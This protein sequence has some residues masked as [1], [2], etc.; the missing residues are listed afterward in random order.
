ME[1]LAN[2][3][4]TA[5]GVLAA[6]GCVV[7]GVPLFAAGRRALRLWR[8]LA[9]LEERPLAAGMH[10]WVQV[11]GRVALE[12][13]L[14][15]P[16]SGRPCAGFELDVIGENT[17]VGG[18]VGERRPFRLEH[19]GVSAFVSPDRAQW[20][21]SVSDQRTFGPDAALPERL[22][23]LL[24]TNAEIRW[25]RDRRAPLRI[26]ERAL[27]PGAVVSVLGVARAERVDAQEEVIELAATGT[28][29]GVATTLTAGGGS[30][31]AELWIVGDDEGRMGPR[32]FSEPPDP[33]KL[34]P[35]FWHLTLVG[36][37]PVL[38]L[39]GLLYLARAAAPLLVGRL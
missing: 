20:R 29:D 10:G 5:L 26:V 36:F 17:R 13:P 21:T 9:R 31:T 25:L 39:V 22:A 28:D 1:P 14:F 4:I 27:E 2:L 15:A 19:G 16:L 7:A 6:T 34:S 24:E 35:S 11:S 18:T 8:V 38:S 33:R 37:G 3:P 23:Q 32:V 12:S 30:S